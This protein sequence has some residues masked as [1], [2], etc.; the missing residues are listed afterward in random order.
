M[1]KL[2]LIAACA[3][4]SVGAFAQGLVNFDTTKGGLAGKILDTD[5]VTALSG[6][7]FLAQLYAGP[8]AN[9]LAPVGTTMTFFT[10]AKAGFIDTSAGATVA[11]PTVAVGGTASYEVRAWAASGGTTYAAAVGAGAHAGI[12]AVFTVAGL[13][14]PDAAG[15]PAHTPANLTGFKGFTLTAVPEPSTIALGVLGAAALLLRRRN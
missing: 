4:M 11:I 14:G 2:L 15:G 10:G 7:S 1:K 3:A 12:A 8:D 5:G 6:A 9:S 13:G